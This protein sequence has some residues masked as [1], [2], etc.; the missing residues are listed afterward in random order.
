MKEIQEY[1]THEPFLKNPVEA[2][3][4]QTKRWLG[5]FS[6]N[7][8]KHTEASSIVENMCPWSLCLLVFM[9]LSVNGTSD[10][11][12][13]NKYSKSDGITSMTPLHRLSILETLL[14]AWWKKRLCC[15]SPCGKNHKWSLETVGG[16]QKL[17]ADSSQPPATLKLSVLKPQRTESC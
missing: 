4:Y 3:L 7:K 9:P 17:R 15:G 12:L 10:F 16:L 5:N 2:K 8:Y 1:N 11:P 13:T 14:L 6:K